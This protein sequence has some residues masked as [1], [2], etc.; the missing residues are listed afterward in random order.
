MAANM[1]IRLLVKL[2]LCIECHFMLPGARLL[3]P[4]KNHP[5]TLNLFYAVL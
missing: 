4:N 2:A 5:S 3:H 1:Q